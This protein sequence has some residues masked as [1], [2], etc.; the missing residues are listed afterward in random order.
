MDAQGGLLGLIAK[1][2]EWLGH[3]QTLIAENVANA[4]TPKYTPRDLKQSS[5]AKLLRGPSSSASTT[6]KGP[7]R[8]H[9]AHLTS[10]GGQSSFQARARDDLYEVAP[11]GNAVVLE[12]ELM[13]M[14]D[15]QAQHSLMVNLYRKHVQLM[16]LALRGPG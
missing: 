8:T 4:D 7:A 1:R 16:K 3:R 6:A 15:V 9:E 5:F 13:K 12:Q 2:M 10:V 14:N 11:S